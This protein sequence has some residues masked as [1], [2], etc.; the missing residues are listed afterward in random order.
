MNAAGK[1]PRLKCRA[2][3]KCRINLRLNVREV[4]YAADTLQVFAVMEHLRC[5]G[6]ER[7]VQSSDFDYIHHV[8]D[9]RGVERGHA[10]QCRTSVTHL[11]HRIKRC[12]IEFRECD[13]RRIVAEELVSVAIWFMP[14]VLSTSEALPTSTAS[15]LSAAASTPFVRSVATRA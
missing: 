5:R 9:K 12:R 10:F 11:V 4:Q 7:S 8:P 15:E 3:D 2:G 14:L 1:G 13:H 6:D